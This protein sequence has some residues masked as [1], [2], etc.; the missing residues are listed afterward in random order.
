MIVYCNGFDLLIPKPDH[1]QVVFAAITDPDS[2]VAHKRRLLLMG[3]EFD[4]PPKHMSIRSAVEP[5]DQLLAGMRSNPEGRRGKERGGELLA[6]TRESIKSLSTVSPANGIVTKCQRR[7]HC[8][9]DELNL[10]P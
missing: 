5:I 8:V 1:G 6:S 2:F 7:L 10:A 4:V 9:P 3:R